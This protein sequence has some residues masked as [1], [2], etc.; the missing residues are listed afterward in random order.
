[1]HD[2]SYQTDNSLLDLPNFLIVGA[3]KSGTTSIYHYL[4]Q[5][6]DIFM[7][8]P[9]EPRFLSL[10]SDRTFNGPGDVLTERVNI[11][12]FDD[13]SELFKNS[14]KYK[15]RGEASVD[16]LYFHWNAIPR[17]K[18]YLGD[19]KIIIILRNPVERAYS[20]YSYL[21]RDGWETLS[22]AEALRV[23]EERKRLGYKWMW[24]YREAGLY[25]EQV[26]AYLENFAHV[27]VFLYDDLR[28]D[29]QGL[30]HDLFTFLEVDP[31]F[32]PGTS[33]RHN[34][35]GIPRSTFL[36]ALFVKPKRLHAMARTVGGLLI[37][38]QNWIALRE[39][40]RSLVLA[41]PEPI[42]AAIAEELREYYR[43]DILKLERLAGLDLRKWL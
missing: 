6:P 9:K 29:P 19:P 39:R 14:G 26:R 32:L 41:K 30:I 11:D 16:S 37:G 24:R 18:R 12:T 4:L 42:P 40:V 20:A 23:E 5:H 36:N 17:I 10:G 8:H 7:C 22:F 2:E 33:T 13:Y 38:R 1:M 43:E 21:R 31:D 3:G 28:S 15:A 27:R 34:A 35:S 25:S